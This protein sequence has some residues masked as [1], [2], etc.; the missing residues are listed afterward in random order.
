MTVDEND[1]TK[2]KLNQKKKFFGAKKIFLNT[3]KF[4]KKLLFG[5]NIFSGDCTWRR[6]AK[7]NKK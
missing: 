1:L 4:E 6:V 3:P 5:N 7:N 2:N